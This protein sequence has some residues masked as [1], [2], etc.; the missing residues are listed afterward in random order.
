MQI[1]GPVLLYGAGREAR[2]TARFL[3]ERY[4][5]LALYV[6]SDDGQAQLD[7]ATTISPDEASDVSRFGTII[8]S[9]GVSLYKPVFDA[10]RQAGV[11]ITSNLNIWGEHFREGRTIVA[12]SGTKGKSTTA[13]LVHLMLE[14]SGVDVILAGNVGIPPLDAADKATTVVLEL[15]SYQTADIGFAPDIAAISNLYPEHV[16]WHGGLERYYGDKLNLIAKGPKMVAV[17][18]QAATVERVIAS[19]PSGTKRVPALDIDL[20]DEILMAAMH[21]R[22]KGAHNHDNARLAAA[23]AL[24]AGATREGIFAGIAAFIPLPHRLEELTVGDAAVE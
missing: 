14:H 5:D 23:I 10:A 20:G 6:T 18:P 3:R 24:A 1:D 21:S 11:P 19:I 2:S 16:D 7:G 15:S 9:P 17:G 12:I 4:P 22:L 13:T 8:K